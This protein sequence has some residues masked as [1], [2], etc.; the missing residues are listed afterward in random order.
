M[1]LKAL[2]FSTL[3][4]NLSATAQKVSGTA[5]EKDGVVL[6]IE[7]TPSSQYRHLGTVQCATLA[8]DKFDLMVQHMIVKQ[9]RKSYPAFDA[10]VF[11]SGMGLC[12]ADVIQFYRD[13]KAKKKKVK[14]GE[15]V[16]VNPEYKK[17]ETMGK[18]GVYLFIENNPTQEFTLLGKLELPSNFR[19]TDFEA[20]IKEMTRLAKATYPDFN[21]VVFAS[22]SELRKANIV[23]M[24]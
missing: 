19:S 8:P 12:K 10:L 1:K 7:C 9:A 14:K 4:L 6:Y 5:T 11:R 15:V 17:S 23:K 21:G 20:T 24:K 2:L 22:G 18:D 13:P 3:L 16:E